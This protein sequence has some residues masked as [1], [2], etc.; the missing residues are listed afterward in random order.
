MAGQTKAHPERLRSDPLAC[1]TRPCGHAR[2]DAEE[3][4]GRRN[5]SQDGSRYDRRNER[6][7]RTGRRAGE[8]QTPADQ[9]TA[10]IPGTA[11]GEAEG[12]ALT[13]PQMMTRFSA[14]WPARTAE[15]RSSSL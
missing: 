15:N 2:H 1:R 3:Q 7:V 5:R 4:A 9:G 10:G 6:Y 14:R 8:A 13:W 12:W 11:R